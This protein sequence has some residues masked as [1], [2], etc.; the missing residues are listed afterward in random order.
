M[1]THIIQLERHDDVISTRDKMIWGSSQRILLVFPERGN[2]L[3]RRIDLVLLQRHSAALGAQLALVTSNVSIRLNARDLGIIVFKSVIQAQKSPWRVPLAIRRKF[4][5]RPPPRLALDDLRQ[6]LVPPPVPGSIGQRLLIFA[7]GLAA[8]VAL[9]LFL[10][11]NASILLDMAQQ[12]QRVK[13]NIWANPSIQSPNLSGGIPA[14][15]TTVIVEGT[16]TENSTGRTLLAN[17]S[18]RGEVLFVNLTD[19]DVLV[20]AG[21]IVRTRI[22]P[23]VRFETLLSVV[24]K[25]ENGEEGELIPVRAVLAGSG[26]NVEAGAIEAI[27]GNVGPLLSV[28][29]PQFTSGGTDQLSPSP[30]DADFDRARE[31][32][33]ERLRQQAEMEIK[34]ILPSDTYYL[35]PSIRMQAIEYEDRQPAENQPGDQ[36]RITVRAAFSAWYVTA[37]NIYLAASTALDA[38]LD[39]GYAPIPDTMEIT[40]MGP[41]TMQGDNVSYQLE[42]VRQLKATWSKDNVVHLVRGKD[43]MTAAVVVQEKLLLKSPPQF[44]MSPHWWPRLPYLP[45]RIQVGDQ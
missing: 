13:M 28:T 2:I 25:G 9:V 10:F 26:G 6:R 39:A 42:A 11:P 1:K 20:P 41:P 35:S 7:F 24:V 19:R 30:N 4:K 18:A 43:L 31:R 16:E 12:E 36:L 38:N 21:T 40:L 45:F 44:S 27:E 33:L 14:G 22:D 29:N 8:V 17:R 23:V 15:V 34:A 5:R 37:E 32:L 3:T